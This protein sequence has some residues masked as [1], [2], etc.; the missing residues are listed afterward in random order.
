MPLAAPQDCPKFEDCR[1][2]VCPL[3]ACCL[4]TQH[5]EGEPV[6]FYLVEFVK[7]GAGSRF[8]TLPHGD[9]WVS[10]LSLVLPD[11]KKLY[12]DIRRKLERAENTGPRMGR[13]INQR[14]ESSL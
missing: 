2:P 8:L 4:N 14:K 6:C 11:V 13:I 12:P 1:A 7:E 3:D 9:K 10:V 5:L